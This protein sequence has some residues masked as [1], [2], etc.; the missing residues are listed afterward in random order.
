MTARTGMAQ[1]IS[2]LRVLTEAGT[3]EWTLG[4]ISFWDDDQI[5]NVLDKHVVEFVFSPMKAITTYATDGSLLYNDY[6]I[7]YENV[8]Q[9]TDGTSVFYIQNGSFENIGTALY[10][11]NYRRGRFTF[12]TNTQGTA[13]FYATGRSYDLNAAAA[14]VW[15]IKANHASASFDFDTDNTS[16]KKSQIYEHYRE[17]AEY[18]E[19]MSKGGVRTAWLTRS[20]DVIG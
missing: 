9:T 3:A 13:S 14:E 19:A 10:T 8:E 16:V 12:T 20:D 17:R 4:T 6:Q 2:D 15:R 5:Q 11:P 1:L 7:D 18:F